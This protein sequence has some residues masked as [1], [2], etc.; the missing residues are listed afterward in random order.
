[1]GGREGRSQNR[2]LEPVSGVAQTSG[3]STCCPSCGLWGRGLLTGRSLPS[4][5]RQATG[6]KAPGGHNL[7]VKDEGLLKMPSNPPPAP[8]VLRPKGKGD[9]AW[10][11]GG[12]SLADASAPQLSVCE[13]ARVSVC[14]CGGRGQQSAGPVSVHCRGG[15]GGAQLGS[16]PVSL[17]GLGWGAAA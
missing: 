5:H 15:G 10:W 8:V 12:S 9:P 2:A 14:A 1:M 16:I 17:A 13:C 11:G 4:A 7:R 3:D 6:R